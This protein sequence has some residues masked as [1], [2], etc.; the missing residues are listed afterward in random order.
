MMWPGEPGPAG[1]GPLL[2]APSLHVSL[3]SLTAESPDGETRE[4]VTM[5]RAT[6]VVMW[7]K[8]L[9]VLTAP[10]IQDKMIYAGTDQGVSCF[11]LRD[12]SRVWTADTGA[13]DR[14]ISIYKERVACI[15]QKNHLLILSQRD[16]S[17]LK[18]LEDAHGDLSPLL[19]RS[20]VVYQGKTDLMLHSFVTGETE[21]WVNS[22]WLGIPSSPLILLKSRAYYATG[23]RGLICVKEK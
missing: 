6:G 21:Q 9:P 7:R 10:L 17:L 4:L 19:C 2:G 8:T 5:D 3:L 13:V 1:F 15:N 18:T 23:K 16:G 14:D 20:G 11:R 22:E 12:G